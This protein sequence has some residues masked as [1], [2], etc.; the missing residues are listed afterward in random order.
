MIET[1]VSFH[2][3][4]ELVN[5][6]NFKGAYG[7]LDATVCAHNW[8]RYQREGW[9]QAIINAEAE[10]RRDLGKPLCPMEIC[11]ETH[12]VSDEIK[13]NQK[14]V[15]YLGTKTWTDWVEL[16]LDP[17]PPVE[18]T[19][20]YTVEICDSDLVA[21]GVE[22][23]DNIVW[24]YPD[25]IL[26]C[27]SGNQSLQDPC[28]TRIADASCGVGEN[29]YLFTWPVYQLVKPLVDSMQQSE[30]DNLITAVKWRAWSIDTDSIYTAVEPCYCDACQGTLP[31]YT[32]QLCDAT[33]GVICVDKGSCQA[34]LSWR[35][36]IRI[37]YAT[38]F[39]C[40]MSDQIDP[41]IE[42]A[43]A[44]LALVKAQY[45]AVKPCVCDNT[46]I[47]DLLKPDP[48]A[49]TEYASKLRYGPTMAGM[50]VW[51]IVDKLIKKPNF[52][53]P[54]NVGGGLLSARGNK[55]SRGPRVLDRWW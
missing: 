39:G 26:D 33:D 12:F 18:G 38:A 46:T 20:E 22:D 34:G 32:V 1:C 47:D 54:G 10:L 13:L 16:T 41:S 31:T 45:T 37:N 40:D 28:V 24:S 9:M 29:G 4:L 14:P 23:V 35:S 49:S 36:K 48:S 17:N 30:V 7:Y 27:Y 2:R 25:D 55:R 50:R 52:N 6:D 21:A 44:L 42:E 3:S 5:M 11:D 53:Q 8:K 43:I 15:A 19:A 51:R